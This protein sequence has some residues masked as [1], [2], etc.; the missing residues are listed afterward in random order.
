MDL[1]KLYNELTDLFEKD[2][3]A[4]EKRSKEIIED[5]INSI[6]EEERRLRLQRIQW[7]VE[8]QLRK[9]KD[10]IARMNKMVELFWK[11]FNE[12][13]KVLNDPFSYNNNRKKKTNNIVTFLP[14]EKQ[15]TDR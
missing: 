6:P 13:H 3:S 12:F 15:S 10:P 4:A 1:V 11:Q 14:K 9:Y 5:F 2:P 7:N 8:Q